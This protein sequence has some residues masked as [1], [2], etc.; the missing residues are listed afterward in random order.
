MKSEVWNGTNN[1]AIKRSENDN[2]TKEEVYRDHGDTTRKGRKGGGEDVQK[3]TGKHAVMKAI[4]KEGENYGRERRQSW[5]G[6][7]TNATKRGLRGR[8]QRQH[9]TLV[10][11]QRLNQIE[12]QRSSVIFLTQEV[13]KLWRIM[14]GR[15][16]KRDHETRSATGTLTKDREGGRLHSTSIYKKKM[17]RTVRGLDENKRGHPQRL[18]SWGRGRHSH[19]RRELRL[20]KGRG[21]NFGK[22]KATM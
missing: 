12:A 3:V 7:T 5:G 8:R 15:R 22:R 4:P 10:S 13:W 9:Q 11:C 1:V 20:W 14:G 6:G 16:G 2:E 18:F 19:V 21:G 17:N